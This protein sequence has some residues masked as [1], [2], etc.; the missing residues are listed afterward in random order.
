MA[1]GIFFTNL[2]TAFRGAFSTP[3]NEV[4]YEATNQPL[5][6]VTKMVDSSHIYYQGDP[7]MFTVVD[8]Q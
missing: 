8:L 2:A 7:I 1:I 3:S 4:S 5:F 6:T